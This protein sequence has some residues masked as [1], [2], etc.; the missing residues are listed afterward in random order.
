M[1][2]AWKITVLV[3]L[4]GIGSAHALDPEAFNPDQ[5]NAKLR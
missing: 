1:P 5:V 2:Q 3:V 4:V